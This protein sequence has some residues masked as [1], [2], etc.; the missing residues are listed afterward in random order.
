MRKF[1][2]VVV[3]V[4]AVSLSGCSWINAAP[5][6]NYL[7]TN[8]TPGFKVPVMAKAPNQ[9]PFYAIDNNGV[10]GQA[11]HVSLIPPGSLASR[12]AKKNFSS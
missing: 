6:D 8:S 10:I 3:S 7:K 11:G 4:M 12:Q 5:N 2:A 9:Q 1:L